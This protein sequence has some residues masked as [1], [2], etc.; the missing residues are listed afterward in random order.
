MRCVVQKDIRITKPVIVVG[1][2][3]GDEGKGSVVDNIANR[4]S[5]PI[6]IRFSG[7]AQSGHTTLVGGYRHS[8][9]QFGSATSSGA[10]TYFSEH[11]LFNPRQYLSEIRSLNDLG[12]RNHTKLFHV[13]ENALVTT[14]YH[15]KANQAK[16]YTKA[17]LYGN[18]NGTCGMGIAETMQHCIDRPD[19]AVRVKDLFN[20]EVLTKKYSALREYYSAQLADTHIVDPGNEFSDNFRYLVE[21]LKPALLADGE[22]YDIRNLQMV[23]SSYL[24]KKVVEEGYLPIFEGTQGI[25]LHELYGFFPHVTW[26]DT[27][28]KNALEILKSIG[29]DPSEATILGVTRSYA[30]RHGNGPLPSFNRSLA[31]QIDNQSNPNNTWQGEM[32]YGYLDIPL[33]RYAVRVINKIAAE[34]GN[35]FSGVALTCID[36]LSRLDSQGIIENHPEGNLLDKRPYVSALTTLE[37]QSKVTEELRNYNPLIPTSITT[38]D[39]RPSSALLKDII[40]DRVGKILMTSSGENRE[41]KRYN[42]DT[43]LGWNQV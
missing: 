7:G 40:T 1:L 10:P 13:H 41:D 9:R 14:D 38:N 21:K 36:Q 2:G 32:R 24:K 15:V 8:Y 42:I 16:E 27:S 43:S 35:Q 20:K 34:Y 17:R 19:E 22:V 6:V 39:L 37:K 30:H 3:F 28:P 18:V 26:A 25:L 12:I 5:H 23:D 33:L 4:V 29:A 31:R 11:A